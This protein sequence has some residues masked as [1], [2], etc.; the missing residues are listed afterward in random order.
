M[1]E[2]K[3]ANA[4]AFLSL[5]CLSQ[6]AE[7][8]W[9]SPHLADWRLNGLRDHLRDTIRCEEFHDS[10]PELCW[11]IYHSD[12]AQRMLFWPQ[13]WY[14]ADTVYLD[15]GEDRNP[16]RIWSLILAEHWAQS[17]SAG[18]L[19]IGLSP[20]LNAIQSDVAGARNE[21]APLLSNLASSPLSAWD[22]NVLTH[23]DLQLDFMADKVALIIGCNAL[24]NSWR[25]EARFEVQEL[26]EIHDWGKER[27]TQFGLREC[28][29]PFPGC[30]EYGLFSPQA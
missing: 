20:R 28:D 21:A 1:R 13:L 17:Q 22:A 18:T 9:I 16:E 4:L 12:E 7:K 11:R 10:Y 8:L 19:L 23:L 15:G 24:V 3:L 30:W 2:Q 27:A 14:W 29:M 6:F 26:R 25:K 5:D